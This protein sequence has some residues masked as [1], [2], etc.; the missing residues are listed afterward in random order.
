MSTLSLHGS[1]LAVF[2]WLVV[3][4]LGAPLPE[5]AALLVT[6][7]MIFHHTV[8]A[9]VALVVVFTGVLAGDV[10]LFLLARRL[11]PRVLESRWLRRVLTPER[12]LRLEHLYARHGSRLVFLGRHLVGLRAATFVLAGVHRMRVRTFCIWDA[13]A[14]CVSVPVVIGLGYAGALHLDRVRADV[15]AVERSVAAICIL[16]VVCA[17]VVRA[18]LRRYRR[19]S[20]NACRVEPPRRNE[21][22]TPVARTAP[23]G[24]TDAPPPAMTTART[25]PSSSVESPHPVELGSLALFLPFLVVL[26]ALLLTGRRGP[27]EL[28]LSIPFLAIPVAIALLR[29]R[30]HRAHQS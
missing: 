11:G 25:S 16:A 19:P 12:N 13:V 23:S 15:A 10:M 5:D 28:A 3:G 29:S 14:A 7:S 20:A 4:G 8:S 1:L 30:A 18:L 27:A 22:P 6:G 26:S 24:S 9:A 2:A 21:T 17:V